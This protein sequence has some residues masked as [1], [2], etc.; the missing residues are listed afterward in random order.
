MK[1]LKNYFTPSI[2][3]FFIVFICFAFLAHSSPSK[4][5][6]PVATFLARTIAAEVATELVVR[7][8]P[9]RNKIPANDPNYHP[10]NDDNYYKKRSFFPTKSAIGQ[11]AVAA[12]LNFGLSYF[13]EIQLPNSQSASLPSYRVPHFQNSHQIPTINA[14]NSPIA[15]NALPYSFEDY[16]DMYIEFMHADFYFYNPFTDQT[17]EGTLKEF[18]EHINTFLTSDTAKKTCLVG[19]FRNQNQ[20]GQPTHIYTPYIFG[21]GSC[22]LASTCTML[23]NE[24][25]IP[26]SHQIDSGSSVISLMTKIMNNPSDYI[27]PSSDLTPNELDNFVYHL[28]TSFYFMDAANSSAD[29][30][31]TSTLSSNTSY[32]IF[33]VAFPPDGVIDFQISDGKFYKYNWESD[34]EDDIITNASKQIIFEVDYSQEDDDPDTLDEDES[35]QRGVIYV[36]VEGDVL[37]YDSQLVIKTDR[38][39]MRKRMITTYDLDSRELLGTQY[40][41]ALNED[42]TNYY[43]V[44]KT[45]KYQQTALTANL[46]D[47][48]EEQAINADAYYQAK[49]NALPNSQANPNENQTY[50]VLNDILE[51]IGFDELCSTENGENGLEIIECTPF[52]IVDILPD[53]MPGE[54]VECEPLNYSM[55]SSTNLFTFNEDFEID[56]CPYLGAFRDILGYLMSITTV[57]VIYRKWVKL[58]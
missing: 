52:D 38:G 22:S 56:L 15:Y 48:S 33:G 39:Y 26:Q 29:H 24:I 21:S 5:F 10:A 58:K 53:I 9:E 36:Q 32:Y 7:S 57:Y 17:F 2:K 49:L 4:A 45:L 34:D 19:G 46:Q 20:S 23:E 47:I 55:A 12:A 43:K 35:D 18:C 30:N 37:Q 13:N 28:P 14:I 42:L 6:V 8:I 25:Y 40:E 16:E 31:P 3:S 27:G 54:P 51:S 41:E 1:T 50:E 44:N 11:A